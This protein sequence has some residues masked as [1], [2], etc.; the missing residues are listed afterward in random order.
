VRSLSGPLLAAQKAASG[1]PLV[2]AVA[3]NDVRSVRHLVFA[4]TYADSSPDDKHGAAA[5]ATYLHRCRVNGGN[6]QYQRNASAS[7]T[8]LSSAATA[9]WVAIAVVN[10]TRVAVIYN[11]GTAIKIRESTDAGATFAAEA[12]VV[13]STG[14]VNGLAVAYKS[15]GG[16]L[17]VFWADNVTMKRIR[18]TSGTFGSAASWTQTAATLTGVAVCYSGDFRLVLTGTETTTLRRTLWSL[19]LGDGFD[20]GVDS[21]GQFF[22]QAQGEADELVV[23]QAPSVAVIQTFRVTFVEL[24]SGTTAYT[25][26]YW[27]ATALTGSFSPGSWEWQDPAPL[28]NAVNPATGYAV[29][30]GKTPNVAIYS[31]PSHVLEAATAAVTLDMSADLVEARIEEADGLTQR[32]E[33]VFDNSN[34]QYAGPPAPIALH[35]TVELGLGYDAAYSLCPAQSIVGWEY[36]REGGRARFVLRTRGSDYWLGLARTRTS[37]VDARVLTQIARAAA[38]RAGLDFLASGSSARAGALSIQWTVHAHQSQLEVLRALEAIVAD[39]FLTYSVGTL[40]IT[41]PLAGDAV[42]YTYGTDHAIYKTRYGDEPAPSVVEVEG[43]AVLGQAFDFTR[44]ND[45]KPLQDRRRSPHD[46][47]AGT[48]GDHA[49]ARLRKAVLGRDLGELLTP[50]N[51]GLE[52]GDVV[53]FTDLAIAA[54]AVK[55]RVRSIETVMR[56]RDGRTVYEQRVGLGGV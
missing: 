54:L 12:A 55:G 13:T 53:S 52:V 7:W 8:T 42:D 44:Q 47:T 40:L 37:I 35:R 14:T 31:R 27:T 28:N 39:H 29:T 20:L 19:T 17:C 33:L 49:T 25:R 41:E 16:D 23:F 2:R 22:V 9:V 15:A 30:A 6:A 10:N 50:P 1:L 51:C 3:K 43:V 4:Q 18:R 45:D 46:T 21:W 5:D 32:A 48:V 24:F 26:T 34:G 36:R 11:L 56:R 38:A